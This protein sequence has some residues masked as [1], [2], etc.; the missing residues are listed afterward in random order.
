MSN[1]IKQLTDIDGN[2]VFPRTVT[3][4]IVDPST[5]ATLSDTLSTLA[6]AVANAGG[7]TAVNVSLDSEDTIAM[8]YSGTGVTYIGGNCSIVG[9]ALLFSVQI[10]VADGATAGKVTI[11]FNDLVSQI[12]AGSGVIVHESE[13][14]APTTAVVYKSGSEVIT[15]CDIDST[16]TGRYSLMGMFFFE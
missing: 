3:N 4:A 5:G 2:N 11:Q 14:P 8:S 10:D 9:R 1:Y 13:N 6:T 15:A 7:A 16:K 12:I